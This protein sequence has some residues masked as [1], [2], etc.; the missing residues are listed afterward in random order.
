MKFIL[1]YLVFILV[2]KSVY[3]QPLV[4]KLEQK[5]IPVYQHNDGNRFRFN[6]LKFNVVND[7]ID[8]NS[9]Y[10]HYFHRDQK[11]DSLFF[12][13][14]F[15]SNGQVF[16]SDYYLSIPNEKECNDLNYGKKGFYTIKDSIII[17][18]FYLNDYDGYWL[19]YYKKNKN[20]FEYIKVRKR[21]TLFLI[22]EEKKQT[23]FYKTVFFYN[24]FKIV[25]ATP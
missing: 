9:V 3:S 12:F 8:T 20:I 22:L 18:E 13:L 23:K 6:N 1:K 25:P 5:L 2:W 16:K 4:E 21:N 10:I 15:F 11:H 7:L 14:R 24:K 17:M 19:Y